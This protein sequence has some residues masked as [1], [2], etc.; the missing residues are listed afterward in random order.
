[1]SISIEDSFVHP[2]PSFC[3]VALLNLQFS[4]SST[5]TLL[6]FASR[7][8]FNSKQ[9]ISSSLSHSSDSSY[10]EPPCYQKLSAASLWTWIQSSFLNRFLPEYFS[11]QLRLPVLRIG[12]SREVFCLFY[13]LIDIPF[14]DWD[15]FQVVGICPFHFI[16]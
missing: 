14:L 3:L 8:L 5:S 10:V 15:L 1:M 11:I 9:G 12:S 7:R 4:N 6:A 13:D 2:S 16:F